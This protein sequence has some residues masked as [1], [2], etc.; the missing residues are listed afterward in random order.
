MLYPLLGGLEVTVAAGFGLAGL[1]KEA[2]VG[3]VRQGAAVAPNAHGAG[4]SGEHA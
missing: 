4:V 2:G 3:A 1:A